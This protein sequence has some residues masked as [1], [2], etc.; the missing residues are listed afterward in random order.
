MQDNVF[1]KQASEKFYIEADFSLVMTSG[2][3]VD[4]TNSSVTAKDK[5][6]ADKSSTVLDS[7]TKAVS[8]SD[9]GLVIRVQAGSVSES[10]YK[11]T[12]LLLTQQGSTWELDVMMHLVDL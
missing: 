4:L 10:P 12:F 7:A 5:D 9:K 3:T 6:G 1:S 8:S 2:E 11:L